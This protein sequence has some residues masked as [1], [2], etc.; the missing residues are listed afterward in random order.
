MHLIAWCA[1]KANVALSTV[2]L[3]PVTQQFC[4]NLQSEY[5]TIKNTFRS[6]IFHSAWLA[7]GWRVVCNICWHGVKEDLN[8]VLCSKIYLHL[9]PLNEICTVKLILSFN[10]F[11]WFIG[12]QTYSFVKQF[13][14]IQIDKHKYFIAFNNKKICTLLH[15]MYITFI[16]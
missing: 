2:K 13:R 7:D 3:F 16:M 10:S 15:N 4:L 6:Q 1:S 5:M 14:K 9:V 12:L 8:V 11:K